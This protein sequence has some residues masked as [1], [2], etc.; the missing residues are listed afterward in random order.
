MF[1]LLISLACSLVAL[2]VV[3]RL[4]KTRTGFLK[5]LGLSLVGAFLTVVLFGPA[6]FL[7]MAGS[8]VAAIVCFF[9]NPKRAIVV[10]LMIAALIGAYATI[11]HWQLGEIRELAKLRQEV[12]IESLATR[13]AYERKRNTSSGAPA[14]PGATVRLSEA[15][16]QQLDQFDERADLDYRSYRLKS[17]HDKYRYDFVLSQ[18]FGPMRMAGNRM[19]REQIIVEDR[20]PILVE[21]PH[22]PAAGGSPEPS[23]RAPQAKTQPISQ[24]LQEMHQEGMADFVDPERMGYVADLDHVA[25]FQ[26]HRFTKM[27]ARVDDAW[28]GGWKIERL[29]LIGLLKYDQPTAYISEHLP[30]LDELG[31]LATRTLDDFETA[32]LGRLRTSEDVVIAEEPGRIRML[33]SLRA[34]KNC[35]Q[36]HAVERG[37]LLGALTYELVPIKKPRPPAH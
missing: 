7:H 34:G 23:A 37:E 4:A 24:T 10:A 29:E 27:P 30:R 18:G 25:G 6:L 33:G 35:L 2:F 19:R 11:V 17:L 36:C 15:V 31:Q 26:S 14:A 21:V 16:G 9:F 13:L 5:V 28:R 8:G 12:P 32:A 22:E 20:G 1:M 3:L